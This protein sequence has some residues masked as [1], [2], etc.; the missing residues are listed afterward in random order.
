[1]HN[2]LSRVVGEDIRIS[3]ELVPNLWPVIADSA[4][5]EACVVNLASKLPIPRGDRFVVPFLVVTGGGWPRVNL[6]ISCSD[7]H[8]TTPATPRGRSLSRSEFRNRQ[9]SSGQRV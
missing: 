2:L 8:A 1:M 6:K 4:Q 5:I 7:C 3:L 9:I